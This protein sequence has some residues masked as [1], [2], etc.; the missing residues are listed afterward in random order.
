MTHKEKN[1]V[2]IMNFALA[3]LSI[4]PIASTANN[5][6]VSSVMG[7]LFA[8]AKET[9]LREY[10]FD[11]SHKS[12]KMVKYSDE[13]GGFVKPADYINFIGLG[14]PCN[15]ACC[16]DG[17]ANLV[18]YTH[19]ASVREING[20]LYIQACCSDKYEFFHYSFDNLNYTDMPADLFEAIGL[21]LAYLAAMPLTKN[22]NLTEY[23]RQRLTEALAKATKHSGFEHKEL[24]A[25]HSFTYPIAPKIT[26]FL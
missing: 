7:R 3:Q 9:I 5:D 19:Q 1:E 23:T 15:L 10:V 8:T 16:A 13:N 11:W 4:D 17:W 14:D 22:Q 12:V 21:K 6:K 25:R 2:G 20:R 24:S 26:G 18:I